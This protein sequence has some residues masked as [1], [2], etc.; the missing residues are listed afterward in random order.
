[1]AA[2]LEIPTQPRPQTMVSGPTVSK[3]LASASRLD[4]WLR[5]Q[6]S[7]AMRHAAALRPF[8]KDEFGKDPSSPSDAHIEVVNDLINN[9]RQNLLGVSRQVS[10][11]ATL[12]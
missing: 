3:G 9:L 2:I 6:S 10:A 5:S 11:A 1:M 12:A 4:T 8:G 7:N